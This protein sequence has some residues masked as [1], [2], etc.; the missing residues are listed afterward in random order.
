[1]DWQKITNAVETAQMRDG[2]IDE[3]FLNTLDIDSP[4]ISDQV[5]RIIA[6]SQHA[7]AFMMTAVGDFLPASKPLYSAGDVLGSW[8][9]ECLLGSGGMGD[10]YKAARADGLYEQTVAIKVMKGKNASRK[11]RFDSERQRLASLN[12]PSI[13]KII[14]GGVSEKGHSYMVMEYIEGHSLFD[15]VSTQKLSRTERLGLFRTI[16][17]AVSHAHSQLIIHRDIKSDNVLVDASAQVKL[18][19]FG[20]ATLIGGEDETQQGSFSLSAAAPEQLNGEPLSVQTDV[21]SLGIVLHQLITG[22]LPQR[23]ANGSVLIKGDDVP[24]DLEAILETCLQHD[25]EDRYAS[26]TALEKDIEA[27]QAHLPVSARQGSQF[28]RFGKLLKR[29][30]IA[31]ALA[32]GFVAAL[33]I[34]L[35]VSQ[36]YANKANMEAQKAANELENTK[37]HLEKAD[38][39]SSIS[40]VYVDAFQYAFGQDEKTEIL[41]QRL[42]DYLAINEKKDMPDDPLSMA[43]KSYAIGKHFLSRN[44]YLNARA[45]FEPWVTEG[46][47]GDDMLL[48]IGQANLGHAYKNLGETKL[49]GGMFRKAEVFY[50]GTPYENSAD[51]MAVAVSAALLLDD[52]DLMIRARKIVETMLETEENSFMKMYMHS[53][54]SKMESKI[55]NW[56]ES[57]T[58]LASAIEVI[59]SGAISASYGLGG[60]RLSMAQMDV[61][62]KQNFEPARKQ[63]ESVKAR[64]QEIK[65]ESQTLGAT[66]ELEAIIHWMEGD[67]ETALPLIEQGGLM[68]KTYTGLSKTYAQSLA[69][70]TIIE[71]DAGKYTQ[72]LQT[73]DLLAKVPTDKAGEWLALAALCVEARQK[74]ISAAQVLYDAKPLDVS[75][76]RLNLRQG[77][78]LNLLE[79]EGLKT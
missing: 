72:A 3:D 27:Y 37:W 43:Q 48:A 56:S 1:M 64:A 51:H 21:F 18:V 68:T 55:G 20:I 49:A 75:K 30:P 9:I 58:A 62:F 10:V 39:Q 15:Y 71:A 22:K 28:Y 12:H 59:D 61:F 8:K 13:A 19:D 23:Q 67:Y 16:C 46:Y 2:T 74:G 41:S 14:D 40:I 57:Y 77:F 24:K 42:K 38:M 47:G 53:Q 66:Y 11:E 34:G 78:L 35:G 36:H 60:T 45:A 73:I 17:R 31:S 76:I 54:I 32:A 79:K 33:T 26:V 50:R 7:D 6:Q 44:D 25:P 5:R 65:G 29:A 63:I 69:F 4:D 52:E 70:K